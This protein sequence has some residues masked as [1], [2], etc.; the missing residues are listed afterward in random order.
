MAKSVPGF[1]GSPTLSRNCNPCK[2]K[3]RTTALTTF[4]SPRK[5]D[6][7]TKK[8][9]N[10]RD[11]QDLNKRSRSFF[12]L[13]ESIIMKNL[14]PIYSIILIVLLSFGFVACSGNQNNVDEVVIENVPNEVVE[15]N[16]VEEVV[17]EP[18]EEVVVESSVIDLTDGLDRQ[19]VLDGPAQRIIALAPSN[20]E[21]LF[22]VGA[23]DQVVGREDFANYP[24][25]VLDLPSVGGS[26]GDL[27]TEVILSLEPDL[28]LVSSLSTPEQVVSLEELGLTVYYLTNPTDFDGL[29]ENLRI[30]AQ[31]TGHAEEAEAA[32]DALQARVAIVL[33]ALANAEDTP[34]VFYELDST[35]PNAPWTAGAGTFMDTLITMAK[36]VNMG[37]SF[38]GAWVQ[39]SAEEIIAQDPALIVLG[40]AIW[41]VTPED[42][43]GRPGWESLSAI[44]NGA[45]YPFNDDLASRPGPRLIEGLEELAKLIHPE[46]FE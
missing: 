29:Y 27:N 34:L 46:L 31:L 20:I 14:K 30:V 37:A 44:A 40:D 22:E 6:S 41:G 18:T 42:V 7:G 25:V 24:A 9:K 23:G 21:L 32:I 8:I 1:T 16:E 43:A 19:V 39:V 4:P 45:I 33:D 36:G 13:L 12:I 15:M 35:D 28:V 2:W 3:A 11:F 5:K 26:F 10:L 38:E 17:E